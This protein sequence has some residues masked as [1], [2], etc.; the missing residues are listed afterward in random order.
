MNDRKVT[1]LAGWM[2]SKRMLAPKIV[3][4]LGPHRAYV[5][6]F[7]G[8]LTVVLAKPPCSFEM[9]S[10]LHGDLTN[11]AWTV[12][13]DLYGPLLYRKLRRTLFSEETFQRIKGSL[14]DMPLASEPERVDVMTAHRAFCY[15]VLCWMGR[16]GVLGTKGH[17]NCF[18]VR[19]TANGGNQA[20][21]FHAAVDSI[22]AWRRRLRC[23]TILRRDGL[24]LLDR[25]ADESGQAIYVD[26]PYLQKKVHY[27]HDF[28]DADHGRLAFT[29]SR[30]VKTRVVL[31]Y[32]A[33]PALAEMYPGWTLIDCSRTKHL[34]VQGRRGSISE[35][36]PEVLLVNHPVNLE[37]FPRDVQPKKPRHRR[38]EQK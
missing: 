9:V 6:P 34:A 19:Y 8:P 37:L 3:E 1:A 5:E 7:C 17:N 4:L 14:E 33:D 15:F 24:A 35:I 29:L 12:Q 2:G 36:A 11:L 21:R 18:T 32:Y 23:V 27:E 28:T 22:P 31:S 13:H 10:D 26:P 20:T 16:S 30:F 38:E 25:L